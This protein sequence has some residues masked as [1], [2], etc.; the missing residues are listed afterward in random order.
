MLG[1]L[2][3]TPLYNACNFN[4]ALLDNSN[5]SGT[6]NVAASSTCNMTVL[7]TNISSFMCPSDPNVGQKQ[8]NNSYCAS[9]GATT[10]GL[11]NWSALSVAFCL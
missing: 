11:Y 6:A 7:L 10:T 9:Y 4:F 2:E 5:F 8:N 3:Q 1:Y